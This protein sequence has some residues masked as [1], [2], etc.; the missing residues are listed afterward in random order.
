MSSSK[1]PYPDTGESGE[2][3]DV[4]AAQSVQRHFTCPGCGRSLRPLVTWVK[5]DFPHWNECICGQFSIHWPSEEIR[6]KRVMRRVS[7]K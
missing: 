5:M 4:E 2:T 1:D 7:G 3:Y 6:D